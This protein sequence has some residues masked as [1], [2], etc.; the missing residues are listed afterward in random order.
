MVEKG[1]RMRNTFNTD[2]FNQMKKGENKNM[3]K[4]CDS[5]FA[6]QKHGLKN[7]LCMSQKNHFLKFLAKKS[8]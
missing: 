6:Y 4:F 7:K 8:I 1:R 2:N 3:D 5:S